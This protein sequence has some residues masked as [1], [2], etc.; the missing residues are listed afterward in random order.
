MKSIPDG[1]EDT[2]RNILEQM[3]HSNGNLWFICI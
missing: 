1:G 2:M 3:F